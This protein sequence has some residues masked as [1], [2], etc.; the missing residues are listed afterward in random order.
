M[1]KKRPQKQIK[2]YLSPDPDG[3]VNEEDDIGSVI[4]PSWTPDAPE[5]LDVL[6]N[7]ADDDNDGNVS[8]QLPPSKKYK[9]RE[10]TRAQ[11]MEKA[12]RKKES[13]DEQTRKVNIIIQNIAAQGHKQ[14]TSKQPT[15]TLLK[16]LPMGSVSDDSE[17]PTPLS[18]VKRKPTSYSKRRKN[19]FLSGN[20]LQ[21]VKGAR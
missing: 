19:I 15:E 12:A 5:V 2:Q 4:D 16:D 10:E 20:M 1:P 21:K 13:F 7:D 6:D 17:M 3:N 8:P 11:R 9:E 14:M 18:S